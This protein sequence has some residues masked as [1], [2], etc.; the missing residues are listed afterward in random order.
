MILQRCNFMVSL[1]ILIFLM[2]EDHNC[3]RCELGATVGK[4]ICLKGRGGDN[5][6]ILIFLDA[7]NAIES[8]RGRGIVSEG[9]EWLFWAF[10]RM[11]IPPTEFYI[12]YVLKCWPAPNHNFGKKAYRQVM[13]EAC[14]YYRFATLQLL[15]PKVV[16]AMGGKACEA[17]VGQDKVSAFEGT[18]WMPV[19]P[20]VRDVVPLVW[21]TY[22][23]AYAL[24][25]PAESVGIFRTLWHAAI[26]AG[27]T[28]TINQDLQP[29]DYGT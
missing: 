22:S 17:F 8:K 4:S 10:K 24:Q 7:P 23:P 21:V 26:Q 9:A 14:S 13:V 20:E 6:S 25:D 19:E 28:P 18:S 27:L 16:I 15:Q 2:N 29:Y 5:P 1:R 3:S 11:S 12:D